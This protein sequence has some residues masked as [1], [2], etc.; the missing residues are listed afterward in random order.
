MSALFQRAYSVQIGALPVQVARGVIA[1]PAD[2]STV[3]MFKITGLRIEFKVHKS[4]KK[5]PNTLDLKI[6]NLSKQTR[7]QLTGKGV[8]VILSAGYVGTQAVIFS[9]EARTIDH[10]D[11]GHGEW[12]THV[13][14]GD[15]ERAFGFAEFRA[16]FA[17]GAAFGDVLKACAQSLSPN[18]GNLSDVLSGNLPIANFARGYTAAGKS[19][20]IM[21]ALTKSVGYTWSVQDG[22]FAFVKVGAASSAKAIKISTATGMVGSPDHAAPEKKGGKPILKVKVLL[23]PS[24][25]CGSVIDVE[26]SGIRGQ[27]TVDEVTHTGDSHG[28]P[29]YTEIKAT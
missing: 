6:T 3:K 21:D 29:W 18:L 2:S 27:F 9:G 10:V 28:L 1:Q 23:Q 22:A 24:I 26:A 20:E 19:K 14:C 12:F 15:G 16:T 17:K 11:Q 4:K 8:P 5:E 7:D 25:K 13:Q